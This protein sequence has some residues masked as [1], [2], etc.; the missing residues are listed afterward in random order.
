LIPTIVARQLSNV[1]VQYEYICWFSSTYLIKFITIPISVFVGL[2]IIIII[3]ILYRL[4]LF[5]F[6]KGVANESKDKRFITGICISISSCVLL[7]VAWILGPL[8]GIFIDETNQTSSPIGRAMQWI[9]AILIGFEGVW[10]LIV[11]ILF[12]LNQQ[13]KRQYRLPEPSN[14]GE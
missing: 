13:P 12:Y 7:G 11:N 8:L 9:F 10:V 1:L 3:I 14:E 6:Y 2:N 4:I 5:T